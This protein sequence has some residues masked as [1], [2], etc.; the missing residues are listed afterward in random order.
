MIK[1]RSKRIISMILCVVLIMNVG[2]MTTGMS[3]Y[4]EIG[5]DNVKIGD[6]INRDGVDISYEKTLKKISDNTYE[7]N[8]SASAATGYVGRSAVTERAYRDYFTAEQAGYYL[9]ALW[10][11]DGGTGGKSENNKG[12]EGGT[13]GFVY[14]VVRLLEGET[15]VFDTGGNGGQSSRN[16]Q[17]GGA[18]GGGGHG[19]SGSHAVGGGGG[20]SAVYKFGAGDFES[21]Y[22]NG[23]GEV[24]YQLIQTD[25]TTKYIMIAGGGGGGG[26]GNTMDFI[27]LRDPD[28]GAAGSITTGAPVPVNITGVSGVYFAGSNGKTSGSS[29]SYA[30]RGGTSVPGSI[31]STEALFD[32]RT[33]QPNN[34]LGNA[35]TSL[36]GGAGGNS[37]LRGGG[38]GAGFA[39]GSG[40]IMPQIINASN[41]GGGGGGSSFIA[42]SVMLP[43]SYPA[44]RD[45]LVAA[46]EA[47]LLPV[48]P[49]TRGGAYQISYLASSDLNGVMGDIVEE[50]HLG[51]L[52][53]DGEISEYFQIL[54]INTNGNGIAN[55]TAGEQTFKIEGA[56]IKP[57]ASGFTQEKLNVTLTLRAR[58]DFAGGNDVPILAEGSGGLVLSFLQGQ[59]PV[60]IPENNGTDYVNIPINILL[61]TNSFVTVSGEIIDISQLYEDI[62]FSESPK[63]DFIQTGGPI[64]VFEGASATPPAL[65]DQYTINN[66]TTFTVKCDV[67]PKP[68]SKAVLGPKQ[69]AFSLLGRS[70]ID[71]YVMAEGDWSK[72]DLTTSKTI[73]H[74]A[75]GEALYDTLLAETGTPAGVDVS[76]GLYN[77]AL[78]VS[79]LEGREVIIQNGEEHVNDYVAT[80]KTV[81]DYLVTAPHANPLLVSANANN[82]TGASGTFTV[83]FTGYYMMEAIGG[84][85]GHGISSTS[86]VTAQSGGDAGYSYG[87]YYLQAG[88][89]LYYHAGGQGQHHSNNIQA[90]GGSPGGGN[91][92]NNEG[93]G[94]GGGYSYV[95]IGI[96]LNNTIFTNG[97]RSNAALIVAGGG[98]G[99]G[100]TTGSG[101]ANGG[102]AGSITSLNGANVAVPGYNGQSDA[103]FNELS[104]QG[105]GIN[106]GGQP[107]SSG[108][109]LA[110]PGSPGGFLF[111][112]NARTGTAGLFSAEIGGGGGG[113]GWYGGAGG[114]YYYSGFTN[115]AGG[116]GGGS[117]Y[118]KGSNLNYP[119]VIPNLTTSS[120]NNS[121][122]VNIYLLTGVNNQVSYQVDLAVLETSDGEG[123]TYVGNYSTDGFNLDGI[124]FET[125]V[126]QYFDVVGAVRKDSAGYEAIDATQ[127]TLSNG[128]T[129]VTIVDFGQEIQSTV[130]KN[131]VDEYDVPTLHTLSEVDIVEQGTTETYNQ[132]VNSIS[133]SVDKT[134]MT[135]NSK[136]GTY[137]SQPFYQE[138]DIGYT[139]DDFEII[140]L[141]TPKEE[142][143][144]GNDVPLFTT[145]TVNAKYSDIGPDQTGMVS[146]M[147]MIKLYEDPGMGWTVD[148]ENEVLAPY[149]LAAAEAVD[150]VNVGITDKDLTDG[151]TATDLSIFCGESVS[152]EDMFSFTS[153]AWPTGADSWKVQFVDLQPES[154]SQSV[155]PDIT[156][157]YTRSVRVVSKAVVPQ[158]AIVAAPAQPIEV[159]KTGTVEVKYHVTYD[160]SSL[161]FE[162]ADVSEVVY[163]ES[164]ETSVKLKQG[165]ALIGD[166]TVEVGPCESTGDPAVIL[167]SSQYSYDIET[168]ELTVPAEYVTCHITISAEVEALEFDLEYVYENIVDGVV[169]SDGYH[170]EVYRTDDPIDLSW[171]NSFVPDEHPDPDYY[172]FY[173]DW[174]TEGNVPLTVMPGQNWQVLGYYKAITY[175]L[176]IRYVNESDS[177]FAP[178]LIGRDNPYVLQI[179]YNNFY[180]IESPFV[181]GYI[182]DDVIVSGTMQKEA[183]DVTVEYRPANSYLNIAYVNIDTGE[184]FDRHQEQLTPGAAYNITSPALARYKPDVERV[185]GTMPLD[186]ENVT[187]IVYYYLSVYT[188]TF[189]PNGG[190]GEQATQ[191]IDFD[192]L[193]ALDPG[194][195][196]TRE[197]FVHT[198]WKYDPDGITADFA[199][200]EEVIDLGDVIL[201]AHWS[202][203]SSMLDIKGDQDS[204]YT[205]VL[206]EYRDQTS[207]E[208]TFYVRFNNEPLK[209]TDL[210]KLT[211][212]MNTFGMFA[213]LTASNPSRHSVDSF[214]SFVFDDGTNVVSRRTDGVVDIGGFYYTKVIVT[215]EVY[216]SSVLR[217]FCGYLGVV[218][219]EGYND[220]VMP[221]DVNVDGSVRSGDYAAVQ[222]IVTGVGAMPG[223]GSENSYLFEL[224][225]LDGNGS[226][227]ASDYATL[228]RMVTG[229]IPSN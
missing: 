86:N 192:V 159:E 10:G 157:S 35:N 73:A 108:G 62:D 100:K 22:I 37:N 199:L 57:N 96:P 104:G 187:V 40:G 138:T 116:G 179:P 118:A 174:G 21:R 41:V 229:G 5:T 162:C 105:G 70:V 91:S 106:A 115:E 58:A 185:Q 15:L 142:F 181:P 130:Y 173:W 85:G 33:Q 217:V 14:G 9:V 72:I 51:G 213:E 216:K 143:W 13:G 190:V 4:T 8:I 153:T 140:L 26:G 110:S 221:G 141:L 27:S 68:G 132:I 95:S 211:F 169:T 18:N 149:Y 222:R 196:Y 66:R 78:D 191:I 79:G 158:K 135:V 218:T 89:E 123:T 148:P 227:R 225:D 117:T 83:P 146:D 81:Q 183:R 139:S 188:V 165:Y 20:Y 161:A 30:G 6:T 124:G 223:E 1:K 59:A 127:D 50:D 201:Y 42:D 77:M 46:V 186:G 87:V 170:K 34:W 99:G 101:P 126:S 29:T 111:G 172:G 19:S 44:G 224:H 65:G 31:V 147:K 197:G 119:G 114:A 43:A 214:A 125:E 178:A 207:A 129:K 82:I 103:V 154:W 194:V 176:T 16:N 60:N 168:G 145:D 180:I 71:A 88:T 32:R 53:L 144:G 52:E 203:L 67:V 208:L 210:D 84:K 109:F 228:S 90:A 166:L 24:N 94:G 152:L 61:F 205:A 12:G 63:Y 28:G 54:G 193:E 182:T 136:Q 74:V 113:A 151:F 120:P 175:P 155:S 17:G 220:V 92:S 107:G 49:N 137:L 160:V 156:T 131:T 133:F 204:D 195:T 98:G 36:I 215:V 226:I 11:G 55:W 184:I 112:G 39:G 25:R 171:Y 128:N 202:A 212:S 47:K 48:N 177:L 102:A 209:A 189:D 122:L 97:E 7:L 38:G 2:L 219:E 64:E 23:A 134:P 164:L 150:F 75:E 3:A 93:G 200:E 163:G 56:S 167:T 198:G 69:E 80:L 121:G 76:R 206:G 45:D